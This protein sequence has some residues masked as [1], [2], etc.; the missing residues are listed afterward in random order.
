MTKATYNNEVIWII[1]ASSGIG[2]A[3]AKE[4]SARGARLALSARRK[5]MLETL[6]QSLGVEHKIFALDVT[7][8]EL[9][10]R[11]AQAIRA[12]FGRI[13]R[14][15][16]LAA[17]YTPMKFD[18]FDLALTRQMIEVNLLGAFYTVDAALLIF[19]EQQ[20]GQIALC[21]SVAGYSP[22]GCCIEPTPDA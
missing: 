17:A 13:D 9:V 4:L 7:D 16:F 10:G 6:K 5:E 8:A 18:N 20:K 11:T 15:I 22:F 14:V 12:A 21:G 19:K 1:G 2:A 3:L